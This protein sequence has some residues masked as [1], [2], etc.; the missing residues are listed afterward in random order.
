MTRSSLSRRQ[1]IRN[2]PPKS[3][4]PQT[5]EDLLQMVFVCF[6]GCWFWLGGTSG[7]TGRGAGYGR[8]LRPGTRRV[9]PAHRYVFQT[10]VGRIPAG[11]HVDHLCRMWSLLPK[12]T[13]LCVNPDHLEA[14]TP[15]ENM[16]RRDAANARQVVLDAAVPL[17]PEDDR[18]LLADTAVPLCAPGETDPLADFV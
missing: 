17:L 1:Y 7:D 8:I 11:F 5:L 15:E 9:M 6:S 3:R 2:A 14:I 4:Q 10:F 16:R 13:R 18:A 12:V